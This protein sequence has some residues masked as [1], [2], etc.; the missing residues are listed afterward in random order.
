MDLGKTRR[1]SVIAYMPRENLPLV[2]RSR[3]AN[4]ILGWGCT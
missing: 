2:G 4:A 1:E 3:I